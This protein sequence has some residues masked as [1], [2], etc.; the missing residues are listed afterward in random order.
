M[1]QFII[2]SAAL[3][4][5]TAITGQTTGIDSLKALVP[6]HAEDTSKVNLLVQ[7]A[8]SF[9]FEYGNLDSSYLYGNKA[10]NL[11]RKI[12]W[13][14]GEAKGIYCTPGYTFYVQHDYVK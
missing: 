13:K 12:R 3:L 9:F 4:L 11:A 7:I 8:D 14:L 10:A 2:L 6:E 5:N 1:R